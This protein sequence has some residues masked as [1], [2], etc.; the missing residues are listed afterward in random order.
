MTFYKKY[1]RTIFDIVVLAVSVYVILK[2]ASYLY[3]IAAP[4]F[5]SFAI[6]LLIEPLAAMLHRRGMRK[7]IASAISV[8]IFTFVLIG[9]LAL[10]GIVF[11]SE[12]TQFVSRLP[13]YSTLLQNAW[14]DGLQAYLA[15]HGVHSPALPKLIQYIQQYFHQITTFLSHL[16]GGL[17]STATSLSKIVT[18]LS[19]GILLA[20]FLSLEQQTWLRVY[21]KAP[22][23]LQDMMGF[24]KENV[25]VGIVHYIKA[26]LLL[27][28]ITF[29]ISYITLLLM[30][31]GSAFIAATL[32]AISSIVPIL[33]ISAL[34]IPWLSYL[35]ITHQIH[36]LILIGILYLGIGLFRQIIDPKIIGDSLGVSGFTMLALIVLFTSLFGLIGAILSPFLTILIKALYTE[37][38]LK[39]WIH[40]PS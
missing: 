35:L 19:L 12:L 5:W 7:S 2:V 27:I 25:W 24:L 33:G 22:Q 18:D 30:G 21:Q 8:L 14:N 1:G 37:G 29:G 6:F 20:Y 28:G 36:L 39:K 11:A 17:L 16:F 40:F 10:L 26:Q 23:D 13:Y 31:V 38:Y 34:F 9:L 4:I 15:A 3:H 32:I